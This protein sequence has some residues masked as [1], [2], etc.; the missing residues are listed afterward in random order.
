VRPPGNLPGP[1][2]EQGLR[3]IE[4]LHLRLLIDREHHRV[5]RR[6][7][8]EADHVG[9][10]L[11]KLGIAADLEGLQP[12]RPQVRRLP[13][14]RHVP[15]AHPCVLGHQP[16]APVRRFMRNPLDRPAQ[17]VARLLGRQMPRLARPG[18]IAQAAEAVS[19]VPLTP[20]VDRQP[21]DPEPVGDRCGTQAFRTEQDNPRPLGQTPPRR[22]RADPRRELR[23]IARRDRQPRRH[24][25]AVSSSRYHVH[26]KRINSARH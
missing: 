25:H 2:R 13:Y 14:L 4:R 19:D 24:R 18:P 5:V 11:G 10:L 12:M 23:A 16:Q 6:V 17:D 1:H 3:P 26:G 21:H 15:L 9:H 7:H 8:V 22:G 20:L